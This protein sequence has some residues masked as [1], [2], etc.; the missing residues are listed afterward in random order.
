MTYV[1][2]KPPGAKVKLCEREEEIGN[3][4]CSLNKQNRCQG[5]GEISNEEILY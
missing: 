5:A 1:S 3:T 4:G 2:A